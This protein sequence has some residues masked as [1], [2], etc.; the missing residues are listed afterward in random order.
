MSRSDNQPASEPSAESYDGWDFALSYLE[1]D[2]TTQQSADLQKTNI[3]QDMNG[4]PRPGTN[5]T[6]SASIIQNAVVKPSGGRLMGSS[7]FRACPEPRKQDGPGG[8]RLRT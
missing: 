3:K 7:G 1:A 4:N 2:S 5:M 8:P 6:R